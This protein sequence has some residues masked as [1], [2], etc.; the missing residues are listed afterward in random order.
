M[1]LKKTKLMSTTEYSKSGYKI[2]KFGKPTCSRQ[3]ILKLVQGEKL[4]L[5]PGVVSI[6]KVGNTYLLEVQTK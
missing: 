6:N 3:N 1:K 4:H 2:T 5:L